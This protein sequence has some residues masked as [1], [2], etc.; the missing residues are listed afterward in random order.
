[1]TVGIHA[2]QQQTIGATVRLHFEIFQC[3]LR[4]NVNIVHGCND[5]APTTRCSCWC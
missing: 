2:R 3:C 1:L 4:R 5:N